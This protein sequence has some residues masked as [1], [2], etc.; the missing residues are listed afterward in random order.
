MNYNFEYHLDTANIIKNL[1]LDESGRVQ[2]AIDSAIISNLRQLMPVE[3]G[4][5]Q[6]A[7]YE[8]EPGL[9]HINV[10]YA[11]YQNEGILYLAS[12]GSSWAKRGEKKYNSGKPLNYHGG[13]D[14]GAHFVERTLNEKYNEILEAGRKAIKK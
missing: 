10:P 8:K 1:G 12:N 13:P 2:K 7:T 11:H 5:M 9:I 6:S 14:R 3:E 4:I